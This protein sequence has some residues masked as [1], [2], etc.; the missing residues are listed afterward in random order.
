[1]NT[2]PRYIVFAGEEYEPAGGWRDLKY[3][4]CTLEE[5]RDFVHNKLEEDWWHIV[6]TVVQRIVEEGHRPCLS[7]SPE[8]DCGM[9][10]G[11]ANNPN[12]EPKPDEPT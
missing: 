10:E 7:N 2:K 5:A 1:M 4:C 11:F 8:N 6:D 12:Y 9:L 3:I